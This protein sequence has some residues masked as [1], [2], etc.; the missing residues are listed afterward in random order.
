MIRNILLLGS[1]VLSENSEPIE[2]FGEDT[3]KLASDLLQTLEANPGIG[4]A[5]PQIGVLKRIF[6]IK[7]DDGI[8]RVFINPQITG[9][10]AK[11]SVYQEGCLSIPDIWCDVVRPVGVSIFA[12]DEN[13]KP[14]N[15]DA[16]GLLARCIQHEYDHLNGRLFIDHVDPVEREHLVSRFEKK[17]LAQRR[18][19]KARA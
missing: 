5:G 11:T 16:D 18:K 17:R 19:K 15:L 10:T 7:L 14:F 8:K 3:K 13:G 9:T 4:L 1:E 12:Y 2:D 6:V